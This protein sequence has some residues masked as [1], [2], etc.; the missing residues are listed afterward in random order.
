MPRSTGCPLEHRPHRQVCSDASPLKVLH[1]H[2]A[3]D[4]WPSKLKQD[5]ADCPAKAVHR[6]LRKF[7]SVSARSLPALTGWSG[8]SAGIP[9]TNVDAEPVH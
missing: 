1:R 2:S 4:T 5:D 3:H 6:A 8:K 9:G 7:R